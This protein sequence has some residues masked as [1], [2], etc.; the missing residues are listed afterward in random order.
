MAK[1][2]K[3]SSKK[4]ETKKITKSIVERVTSVLDE[5][6]HETKALVKD[7]K[8]AGKKLAVKL[9]D[10]Q[11]KETS[12]KKKI[13]EAKDFKDSKKKKQPIPKVE[14][15]PQ[16]SINT[17]TIKP[18]T[19][20]TKSKIATI[21]GKAQSVP[22]PKLAIPKISEAPVEEVSKEEKKTP[23]RKP[24][25]RNTPVKAKNSVQSSTTLP[26]NNG[27]KTAKKT[28]VRRRST[29]VNKTKSVPDNEAANPLSQDKDKS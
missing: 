8:K 9:S 2:T 24:I 10:I 6:G 28:T 4:D 7:I 26:E 20:T 13:K 12:K 23:V 16:A 25:T 15:I 27:S 3:K 21:S 14:A 19:V 18:S 17:N 29:P 22:S 1:K 5:L 11:H